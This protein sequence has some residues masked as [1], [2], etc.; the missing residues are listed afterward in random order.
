MELRDNL[1]I[2]NQNLTSTSWGLG[3][4]IIWIVACYACDKAQIWTASD[5]M[6]NLNQPIPSVINCDIFRACLHHATTL[7]SVNRPIQIPSPNSF[8]DIWRLYIHN[9]LESNPQLPAV[10][11]YGISPIPPIRRRLGAWLIFRSVV[12]HFG[13]TLDEVRCRLIPESD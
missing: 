3:I 11:E 8:D 2:S 7:A 1:P 4:A 10:P 13:S 6:M 5:A 12:D 9:Q